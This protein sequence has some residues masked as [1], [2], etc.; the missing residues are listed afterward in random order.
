MPDRARGLSRNDRHAGAKVGKSETR[1]T[2]N[3][4]QTRLV[5]QMIAE[6]VGYPEKLLAAKRKRPS[7]PVFGPVILVPHER[8]AETIVQIAF[9]HA[10]LERVAKRIDDM[11]P[12]RQEIPLLEGFHQVG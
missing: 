12:G 3:S 6:W 7:L 8:A 4:V 10:V 11:V 9:Q 5:K 2:E 1:N